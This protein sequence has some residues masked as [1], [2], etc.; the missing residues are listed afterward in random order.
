MDMRRID[1]V[2]IAARGGR[3]ACGR[4]VVN[5][6]ETPPGFR[7]RAIPAKLLSGS[8]RP[9]GLYQSWCGPWNQVTTSSEASG[10][11]KVSKLHL[12]SCRLVRRP[13]RGRRRTSGGSSGC[14]LSLPGPDLRQ[15]CQTMSP[16]ITV[17]NGWALRM[18]ASGTV[19]KSRSKT[20]KSANLPC[21]M[22][23]RS[24]SWKAA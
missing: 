21:S 15:R 23:P 24:A 7:T 12:R 11:A 16:A 14:S 13:V 19:I 6:N 10:R 4:D 3:G 20:V 17:I 1:A 2:G 18:S 8:P 9:S 22:V 5:D